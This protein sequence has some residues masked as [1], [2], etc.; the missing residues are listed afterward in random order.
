MLKSMYKSEL[1]HRIKVLMSEWVKLNNAHRMNKIR[2]SGPCL[3]VEEYDGMLDA[4]FNNWWSGGKYT[5][6]AEKILAELSE[7]KRGLLTNSGS[8]ANLLLMAAARELYFKDG[9]KILTLSCGFPTTVNP[10]IQTRL[11]PVFVDI[12]LDSLS[13]LPDTLENALKID[14]KIKGVFIANTLG[15]KSRIKELLEISE[16]HNV[17][18]FFDNCDAFGTTYNGHP[19]Q[20]YGKASTFSFYVAH[21]ITMGEGGGIVTDDDE[22]FHVMRGLRNWGKHCGSDECCIRSEDP[23]VFCP[24]TKYSKD[25]DLPHDYMVKY[26]FEWIGYN[27]KPLDLQSAILYE[28]FKKMDIFTKIR[29]DN[30]HRLFSYFKDI[31][32][33]KIWD[34]DD[35]VSPFSFPLLVSKYAPFTRKQ[36]IDYYTRHNIECRMLFGGNLMKHPAYVKKNKYWESVGK[37]INADLILNNFLM[38]GVSQIL[39]KD[40]I[41]KIIEVTA[42]FINN[43]R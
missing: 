24:A 15:F 7:M 21:H 5:I 41:N 31:P 23:E 29:K 25:S 33:F 20:T 1:E 14:P 18:L 32:Y 38:I 8:S 34:I 4:I 40:D 26:Q 42:K 11:I 22:L 10:I 16:K 36:L 43:S 37:H 19:V 17:L 6:K 35:D 9:D 30:Y 27:L 28:Q 3:D 13:L 12:D 39:N 2:Y